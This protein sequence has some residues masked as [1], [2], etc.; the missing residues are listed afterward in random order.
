MIGRF[1]WL[2]LGYI[3]ESCIGPAFFQCCMLCCFRQL[4]DRRSV[5]QLAVLGIAEA[6]WKTPLDVV[7]Q[8]CA[9][10]Q[11]VDLSAHHQGTYTVIQ[12]CPSCIRRQALEPHR[13]YDCVLHDM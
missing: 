9:E 13:V 1:C 8:S 2:E 4:T 5:L 11:I 3:M 7:L 12:A 10:F 6:K